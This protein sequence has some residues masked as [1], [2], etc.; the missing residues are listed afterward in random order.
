MDK[1]YPI[2][3]ERENKREALWEKKREK[4]IESE[5]KRER[6]TRGN[7]VI[8]NRRKENRKERG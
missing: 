1:N 2:R 5:R 6:N 8:V 3:R 7:T 4:E